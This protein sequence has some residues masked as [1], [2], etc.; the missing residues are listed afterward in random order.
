MVVTETNLV[1]A[2]PGDILPCSS[3]AAVKNLADPVMLQLGV[4]LYARGILGHVWR[5]QLQHDILPVF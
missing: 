3:P 5:R 4:L 1:S 2:T